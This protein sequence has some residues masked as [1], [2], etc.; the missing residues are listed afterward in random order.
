ML[1][2]KV[3]RK[4][5]AFA[6]E[7]ETVAGAELRFAIVPLPGGAEINFPMVGKF[8]VKFS[9]VW[10]APDVDR[11]PVV[12]P[13]SFDGFVGEVEAERLNQVQD[14]SGR[15]AQPGDIA[16]VLRNFSDAW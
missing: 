3:E 8:S 7:D 16:G 9:K 13:G 15:G 14:R 12:E 2:E 10:K 11:V 4:A 5:A 6:S 1:V